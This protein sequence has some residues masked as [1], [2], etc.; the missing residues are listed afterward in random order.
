[1]LGQLVR[2]SLVLSFC[3]QLLF[4]PKQLEATEPSKLIKRRV[5]SPW[6]SKTDEEHYL[7][8]VLRNVE[9]VLNHMGVFVD[10]IDI[11]TE[12]LP[13][14][15][16]A[17]FKNKYLGFITFF[18]KESVESAPILVPWLEKYSKTGL[19]WVAL[20]KLGF[21]F[22]VEE[23][24]LKKF[25]SLFGIKYMGWLD[26]PFIIRKLSAN[27]KMIGYE[28]KLATQELKQYPPFVLPEFNK[29]NYRSIF[30]LRSKEPGFDSEAVFT[31]DHFS[32]AYGDYGLYMRT[33]GR[34]A[35][36]VNPFEFLSQALKINRFYP[37]PDVSVL[38]GN[39]VFF[40]HI[41]GDAFSS[42]SKAY[43]K[44]YCG[45][46]VEEEVLKKYK[47][48]PFGV[49]IIVAEIDEKL[50]GNSR[51]KAAVK[52]IF[53]LPNVE[54][55]S[56]TYYHPLIWKRGER[57]YYKKT[58]FEAKRET[59][60]SIQYINKELLD[61]SK[62]AEALYW[63]GD[64][65]PKEDQIRHLEEEN[66]LNMNGGDGL[67][68]SE[69]PSISYLSPL[70]RPV[71]KYFQV[72]S[73]NANDFIYTNGWE[74]PFYFGFRKVIETFERTEAPILLKPIN[75]YFHFYSAER[76]PG[77]VAI[78]DSIEWALRRDISPI[79]PS[80]YIRSVHAY[81]S[82]KIEKKSDT[83]FILS[84]TKNL[85]SLRIDAHKDFLPD[86]KNSKGILG[87]NHK[88]GSLYIHLDSSYQKA[89]QLNLVNKNKFNKSIRPY[90]ASIGG[91]V[92]SYKQIKNKI[93][94]KV[95]AFTRGPLVLGGL[96]SKKVKI[97]LS[98]EEKS[99]DVLNGKA[100]YLFDASTRDRMIE[101]ML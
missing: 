42:V 24:K 34:N 3:A 12:K 84:N 43:K 55:A 60:G 69:F 82:L 97:K 85:Y 101:V 66:F 65:M 86:L 28:R 74:G 57:S 68:D 47:N 81:R 76:M 9:N 22:I 46:V 29:K 21:L 1:M 67:Y 37:V 45:E 80:V 19:P 30:K 75:P 78:Q 13:D 38:N 6:S 77:L 54:A 95:S 100:R 39:R 31:S 56:H 52:K 53:K 71:G 48:L 7:S 49:S 96:K 44:K 15:T 61:G 17:E 8:P 63:S 5:L 14:P 36:F 4:V 40:S 90:I 89:V 51:L 88:N 11:D 93:S 59:A 70:G 41:D 18:S 83:Q 62:K 87:F 91:R 20:G 23:E 35:W 72:F 32:M 98:G 50:L 73:A 33:G 58:Q 2:I 99:V 79:M 64:C 10:Y 26:P 16:T 92:F 25:F 27:E 94:M